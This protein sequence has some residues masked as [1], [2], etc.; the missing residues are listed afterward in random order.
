MIPFSI[1]QWGLTMNATCLRN[2]VGESGSSPI[3]MGL[4]ERHDI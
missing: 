1:K 3:D 2:R 4:R